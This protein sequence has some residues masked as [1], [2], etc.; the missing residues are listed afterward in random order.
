MNHDAEGNPWV[1]TGSRRVFENPWMVVRAD[2][3]VRPDGQVGQYG[4]VE[5]QNR[6][7]GIVALTDTGDTV[8]VGQWRYPLAYYSWEIPEGG[9]PLHESPLDAA[10]RELWEETGYTA[11][12]WTFLGDLATSNSVTNEVGCVFLAEELTPGVAE[13]EGTERLQVRLV[14]F[15]TAV[16]MAV[17]GE[18]TDGL[19]VIGLL[20][21]WH[22]LEGGRLL[23][24][25]SRSFPELASGGCSSAPHPSP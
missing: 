17:T 15:A 4:V 19:A 2:E 6:A 1:T 24:F 5:F 22:Y 18:I 11:A 14:P 16:D 7:V 21:A 9:A 13:P 20:R 23:R 8:L 10:K 12:R 3:V 25:H